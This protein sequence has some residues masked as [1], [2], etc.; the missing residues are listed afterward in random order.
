MAA[1]DSNLG[2]V[3][4]IGLLQ[5]ENNVFQPAF[6]HEGEKIPG[7]LRPGVNDGKYEKND[8]GARNKLFGNALVFFDHGV[9]AGGIDDIK[10]AKKVDRQKTFD[11]LRRDIDC[12]LDITITKNANTIRR[13]QHPRFGE[14]AAEKRI[15]ERGFS[16]F[17]FADDDKEQRLADVDKKCVQCF[18]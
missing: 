7:R 10:V 5:N 18:Q 1:N 4:Q 8:V 2:G 14:F 13:R 11:Q 17:H 6:L 12:L 9:G 3:T 15:E 16:C